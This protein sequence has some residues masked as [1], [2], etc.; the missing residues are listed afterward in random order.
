[1][2]SPAFCFLGALVVKRFSGV[3]SVLA[4]ITGTRTL[5]FSECNLSCSKETLLRI[6]K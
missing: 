1:M 3:L 4:V 2:N 5:G 6:R